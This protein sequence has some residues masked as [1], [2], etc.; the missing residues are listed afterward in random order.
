M[1]KFVKKSGQHKYYEIDKI[2]AAGILPYMIEHNK[3]FVLINK[4][5]RNK[6]IVYNTIG[7]KVDKV[8]KKISD[9]M[10]RE[11]NEETGFLVSDKLEGY[12]NKINKNNCISMVKSKYLLHLM[13][14]D[15]SDCKDWKLLPYTYQKMFKDVDKFNHRESIQLK[16]VDLFGFDFT[17]STS[18]LLK[19]LISKVKKWNKFLNYNPDDPIE[20]EDD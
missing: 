16:W 13:E 20:I 4:E 15:K 11:F 6:D 1:A 9:T 14:I 8:D 18:F 5:E 12:G 7:G 19:A 17:K 3:V 2:R 10:I